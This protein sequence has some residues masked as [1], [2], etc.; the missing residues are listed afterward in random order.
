M[1]DRNKTLLNFFSHKTRAE[2]QEST[3]DLTPK[4]KVISSV[5]HA[6]KPIPPLKFFTPQ[7]RCFSYKNNPLCH[8]KNHSFLRWHPIEDKDKMRWFGSSSNDSLSSS[9]IQIKF[10]FKLEPNFILIHGT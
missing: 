8:T 10:E 9:P 7:L 2:T 3:L 1:G 6:Q 4:R 5:S